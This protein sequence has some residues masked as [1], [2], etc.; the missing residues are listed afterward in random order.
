M[1]QVLIKRGKIT[2]TTT[3][4]PSLSPG[5]ILVKTHYSCIS[6][7]TEIAGLKM[8]AE[9]LW[10]RALKQPQQVKKV[11]SLATQIG[12]K[13]TQALVKGHL[14]AGNP[15]GYSAAGT[16]LAVAEDVTG[17]NIGDRVACAGAQCA[18]HAEILCVPQNLAVKVPEAVPLSAAATVTLGAI[19]L[20][21]VRRANPTLGETFIVLG[22]GI[23]G[24]L[25][26]Q[27]LKANGCHVIGIDLATEKI[28]LAQANGLEIGLQPE[29]EHDIATVKRC[30]DG[31]G[32]DGVI[33]TAA[34]NSSQ[35]VANAF[36]MCRKKGRVILVGDVGLDLKREDLYAKELDFLVSCSY[37]P[38]RYDPQYEEKGQDYPIAYVRW[39]ENRN[40]QAYLALLATQQINLTSLIHGTYPI[41]AAAT[42]YET[43]QDANQL[44]LINLLHYPDNAAEYEQR[45]INPEFMPTGKRKLRVALIGAGNFAKGMHLPNLQQLN[46]LFQIQAIMSRTGH[47]A[48]SCAR[49]YG[50]RYS[51]TN[52]TEILNDPEIDAIILCTPHDQHADQV[53]QALLANKHV[54]VEKPLAMNATE[55][56]QVAQAIQPT[57]CPIVMTGFNRRFSPHIQHLKQVLAKRHS[58]IIINYRLNG[59]YI[60]LNH[61]VHSPHGGGRNIGEACHIYDL[62]TFL[63]D[64]E[65]DQITATALTPTTDYYLSQ[66]NFIA[67]CHFKDGSI[68]TLTYT[69]LGSSKYPKETFEVFFEGCVAYLSDYK[70][71]QFYGRPFKALSTRQSEKGQLQALEQF[72]L[73]IQQQTSWPIPWWQQQQAM[74][75]AFA[76]E[77]ATQTKEAL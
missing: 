3:P 52:Y 71:L 9:P 18:H 39:T 61:W 68:A 57:A 33:I 59:G 38:G 21:G 76:I 47:N 17:F 1:K 55:L 20:Q 43:L 7:G 10:R 50:A 64:T 60:P 25:T 36:A 24:Q 30:T 63:I 29:S 2:V 48:N 75:I 37:G 41:D 72:G 73:A 77:T 4:S 66:D 14:D 8:S 65:V 56:Q 51:T 32:A 69:A 15:T 44:A 16:V 34:S 42:A 35:V 19:A 58:P 67:T 46:T 31:I 27:I 23:L 62:F 54:Y 12:L 49:Q 22:L 26:A 11:I 70:T 40:M 5:C 28:A 74:Q 53:I 45:I 6:K 13:R